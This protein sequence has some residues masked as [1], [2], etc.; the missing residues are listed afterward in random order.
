M[1]LSEHIH[2]AT[3]KMQ[4]DSMKSYGFLSRVSYPKYHG[5]HYFGNHTPSFEKD[6]FSFL[7]YQLTKLQNTGDILSGKS[8]HYKIILQLVR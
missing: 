6:Q 8:G 3:R 2:Q 1:L 5:L 7:L 4:K